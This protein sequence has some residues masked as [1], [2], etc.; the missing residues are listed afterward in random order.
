MLLYSKGFL[1]ASRAIHCLK[2]LRYQ[3]FF[4]HASQSLKLKKRQNRNAR[5]D[6]SGGNISRFFGSVMAKGHDMD[7]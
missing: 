2:D 7:S 3:S 5:R 1:P 6:H 4:S